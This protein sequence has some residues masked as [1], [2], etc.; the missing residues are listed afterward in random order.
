MAEWHDNLGPAR[1]SRK[2]P[3]KRFASFLW[4]ACTL[5]RKAR[6]ASLSR[7]L[8]VPVQ[9]VTSPKKYGEPR[10]GL[11]DAVV[12]DVN[13]AKALVVTDV[14]WIGPARDEVKHAITQVEVE[15]EPNDGILCDEEGRKRAPT[16][17]YLLEVGGE[18]DEDRAK[19]QD[20]AQA[21]PTRHWD[22]P[23]E[24]VTYVHRQEAC[25]KDQW[26]LHA[27]EQH[28]ERCEQEL[29][30]HHHGCPAPH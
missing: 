7:A 13:E 9:D 18:V 3:I 27:P 26:A 14:T 23:V 4:P 16:S 25:C 1:A 17:D 12:L 24:V 20:V 22:P 30:Q 28:R 29:R 10:H 19:G 21:E 8:V 2:L 5:Y 11:F 15:T 6:P